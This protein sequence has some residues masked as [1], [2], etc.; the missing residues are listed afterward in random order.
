MLRIAKIRSN[1][2]IYK[3]KF[4]DVITSYLYN[5]G[6]QIILKENELLKF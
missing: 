1:P 4:I 5:E 6:S 3:L 2:W